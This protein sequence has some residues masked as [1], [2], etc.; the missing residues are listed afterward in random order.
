MVHEILATAHEELQLDVTADRCKDT[1][2]SAFKER[3]QQV[4]DIIEDPTAVEA[5]EYG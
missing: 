3:L 1:R 2:A 5:R 4:I